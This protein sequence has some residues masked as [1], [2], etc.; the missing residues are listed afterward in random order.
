[1]IKHKI[2][3]AVLLALFSLSTFASH[4]MGGE[5][6]WQCLPNGN[7]RFVMKLYRECNGITYGTAENITVINHP[8]LTTIT[9]NLH[10][11]GNP[12]DITDGALDGKT[13]LSPHC[14]DS[15]QEIHCNPA[16]AI[17]NT[18][19]VEEWYFTSDM[20]YPMGVYI[21]GVPSAAGWIFSYTSCCRNPSVNI[22]NGSS[23]SWCLRAVM[24]P[25][26]GQNA[27]PCYD[28]SPAFAEDPIAAICG[29]APFT[30]NNN[31]YD[32]ELD[33]LIYTWAPALNGSYTL[34][35]TYAVGYDYLN[36]FQSTTDLNLFTGEVTSLPTANGAYVSC[37]K[38]TAYK[39]GIMI[40]EV[41]REIQLILLNCSNPNNNPIVSAPFYN[42]M[43]GMFDLFIDTVYAGDLVAFD[44][45]ALDMDLL[46]NGN[47]STLYFEANS[48]DFGHLFTDSTAG[49]LQPPCA[50]LVPPPPYSAMTGLSSHFH[51]QTTCEHA[52][53]YDICNGVGILHCFN[54]LVRDNACPANGVSPVTVSIMVMPKPIIPAPEITNL[55]VLPNGNVTFSWVNAIDTLSSFTMY[56]LYFSNDSTGP[57][58]LLDSI[59]SNLQTSYT[60]NVSDG[61]SVPYYYYFR[62]K[63][64]CDCITAPGEIANNLNFLSTPPEGDL[65]KVQINWDQ[66]NRV[67]RVQLP[68]DGEV[69][70]EVFNVKG[71]AIR[72]ANYR[73][74]QFIIDL[75][76]CSNGVYTFKV[77]RLADHSVTVK[78]I[79]VE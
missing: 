51:W 7:Y 24:Y 69:S 79:V 20:S 43:T 29:S 28:N 74:R 9:M 38:V 18:G 46:P 15:A 39:D 61:W 73:T 64:S 2:F 59:S 53:P 31:A 11:G 52:D 12:N 21:A 5:I 10:P 32:L 60:H 70:T 65:P 54:F 14:Y 37:V 62:T 26:N 4:F 44:F 47:P 41:F 57:F 8:T 35:V 77:T 45:A 34:P 58:T 66:S 22:V 19:A 49:C 48:L 25:F 63:S 72:S 67:V 27:F 50:T 3:L 55:L 71:Q 6:S 17:P 13:E 16:P 56:Y 30:Y 78:K 68:I 42:P 1:M 76:D 75:S 23:T 36:P 33:S 40:A